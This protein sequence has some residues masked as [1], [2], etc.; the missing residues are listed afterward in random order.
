[1]IPDNVIYEVLK[2]VDVKHILKWSGLSHQFHDV[3]ISDYLWKYLCER[4]IGDDIV[5]FDGYY[6]DKYKKWYAFNLLRIILKNHGIV[7]NV[8]DLIKL[9]DLNLSNNKISVIPKEIGQLNQL[10]K[11]YFSHNDISVIPT[12]IGQ[13]SQ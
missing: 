1:M 10:Q 2:N 3:Y 4:D 12:E 13:L 11:L 5:L 8:S 9:K 7:Y 6:I